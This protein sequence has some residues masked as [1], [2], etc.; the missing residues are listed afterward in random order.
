MIS[1]IDWLCLLLY[2]SVLTNTNSAHIVQPAIPNTA[3]TDYIIP[4][5]KSSS[6]V[7]QERLFIA[8]NMFSGDFDQ[9]QNISKVFSFSGD[10]KT[11]PFYLPSCSFF[12]QL[13]IFVPTVEAGQG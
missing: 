2:L 11:F 10:K 8:T 3:L 12:T 9:L 13:P 5:K 6:L 1:F 4:S 7:C